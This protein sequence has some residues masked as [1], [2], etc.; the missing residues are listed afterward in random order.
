MSSKMRAAP[1][2]QVEVNGAT[3]TPFIPNI[4]IIQE[5]DKHTVAMME[6]WYQGKGASRGN[7]KSRGAWAYLKEKTPVRI[8]YG[9]YPGYLTDLLTYV[10]SY[11]VLR[12]SKDQVYS[13]TIV[14]KV[15]YTLVGVSMNMQST[16]HQAWKNMSPSAIASKIAV[17]NGLRAIIHPTKTVYNYRLQNCSD[18]Q[19]LC[20]L[21]DEIGYRF[22]IDNTDLYFVDPNIV[23]QQKSNNVP[24]FWAN[25]SP[26][27]KDTLEDFKP[28]VG[29]TTAEKIPATRTVAG[30]NGNTGIYVNARN[31]YSLYEAFT[32]AP[33]TPIISRY[34]DTF[35]VES[36]QEAQERLSAAS[37]RNQYWATAD[38]TVWGD[39]RVRP[40]HLVELV[41]DGVPEDE[42][43]Q[44]LVQKAVHRLSMP[45]RV[46]YVW[47]GEYHID[48]KLMRNQ[49]YT[50]NYST[51]NN[52]A[53]VNQVVPAKLINGVWK[54][55]NVGAQAY[56]N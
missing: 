44:W 46:G 8:T 35:P 21:A 38:A 47:G 32:T 14:T 52:Q 9:M 36:Y 6:V 54:S 2:Y 40:N 56:A 45:P 26:G 16:I 41:G 18:F 31:Q 39:F 7:A 12:S 19:F 49:S 13:G 34:E 5:T 4:K 53:L 28:T 27:F 17:R 48:M 37:L 43:G 22:F 50:I 29:T 24:Q 25:N 11:K 20:E 10:A 1:F 55:T 33:E 42:K 15:E 23:I 51:P 30:F 3:F